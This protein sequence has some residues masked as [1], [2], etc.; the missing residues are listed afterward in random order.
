MAEATSLKRLGHKAEAPHCMDR[1]GPRSLELHTLAELPGGEAAGYLS[2]PPKTH[3]HRE[4][5]RSQNGDFKLGLVGTC[6]ASQ[7]WKTSILAVD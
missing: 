1:R 3:R 4:Q 2:N 6:T 7:A 5:F